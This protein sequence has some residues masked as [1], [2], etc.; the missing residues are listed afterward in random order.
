MANVYDGRTRYGFQK[1]LAPVSCSIP[2]SMRFLKKPSIAGQVLVT[3]GGSEGSDVG[4][5]FTE[6][7][8]ASKKP[9]CPL[10][11][12]RVLGLALE[13]LHGGWFAGTSAGR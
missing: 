8:S 4:V 13:K 1:V 9:A 6:K 3:L 12:V 10:D 7:V 2:F 5:P 11:S